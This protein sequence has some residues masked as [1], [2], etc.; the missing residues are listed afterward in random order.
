MRKN[1]QCLPKIQKQ[2]HACTVPRQVDAILRRL[3]KAME[4]M[5]TLENNQN[6][7]FLGLYELGSGFPT[8]ASWRATFLKRR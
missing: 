5:L 7:A 4:T 3:Q 6:Q 2:P 1:S 8:I